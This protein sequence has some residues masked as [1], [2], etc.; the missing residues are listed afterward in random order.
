MK[1]LA[2]EESLQELIA[3]YELAIRASSDIDEIDGLEITLSLARHLLNN[4]REMNAV[5]QRV[6]A[7]L[8]I[9]G[10]YTAETDEISLARAGGWNDCRREFHRALLRPATTDRWS[11]IEG[12][13]QQGWDAPQQEQWLRE[14]L[15]ALNFPDIKDVSVEGFFSFNVAFERLLTYQQAIR[16]ADALNVDV[17]KI[18]DRKNCYRIT[19]NRSKEQGEK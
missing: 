6:G 15:K 18:P 16:A 8:S 4:M 1:L 12:E 3:D 19:F 14:N 2:E 9:E 11:V 10:A 7:A 5:Q 13:M 17:E